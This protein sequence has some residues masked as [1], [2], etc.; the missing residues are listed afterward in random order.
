MLVNAYQHP[1]LYLQVSKSLPSLH[2]HAAFSTSLE[3]LFRLIDLDEQL[4]SNNTL[5]GLVKVL[6]EILVSNVVV[7]G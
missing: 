3:F 6:V 5:L 1:K 4:L 2:T 7:Q